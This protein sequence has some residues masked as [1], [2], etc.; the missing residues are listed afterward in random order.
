M[1]LPV[2]S[3]ST[4]AYALGSRAPWAAAGAPWVTYTL[5][6]AAHVA[7][8]RA[9]R[10]ELDE[11]TVFADPPRAA[12]A[13]TASLQAARDYL[14]YSYQRLA[15]RDPST[16]DPD[17]MPELVPAP[18]RWLLEEPPRLRLERAGPRALV[19]VPTARARLELDL[20]DPSWTLRHFPVS[21]L[22]DTRWGPPWASWGYAAWREADG[23]RALVLGL[24]DAP[25][26]WLGGTRAADMQALGRRMDDVAMRGHRIGSV[27]RTDPRG[28]PRT[29]AW[30]HA[31]RELG[32]DHLRLPIVPDGRFEGLVRDSEVRWRVAYRGPAQAHWRGL[33]LWINHAWAVGPT[34]E[35]D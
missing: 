13:W 27:A 30:E 10:A 20:H 7:L 12:R 8:D 28:A 21:A 5:H 15:L 19:V 33:F 2:P 9:A 29:V 25:A 18:A 6:K 16:W 24:R 32:A 31:Q 22:M 14:R 3:P 34:D 1:E 26:A 17:S 4:T 35:S 23:S 11:P